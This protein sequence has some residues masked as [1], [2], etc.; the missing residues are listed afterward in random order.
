M[1]GLRQQCRAEKHFRIRQK[2][3]FTLIEIVIV[4]ALIALVSGVAVWRFDALIPAMKT[5]S[6]EKTL[7]RACTQAAHYA[8]TQKRRCFLRM[9][10]E[11]R[12]LKIEDAHGNTISAFPFAENASETELCFR[13]DTRE[14]TRIFSPS[15]LEIIDAI[16]FHPAGC[17]TPAVIE[18]LRSRKAVRCFRM[19]PFSGGLTEEEPL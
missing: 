2:P 18:I 11:T 4:I 8:W 19:D 3:A 9:D 14:S 5:P 7:M 12:N 6:P 16:E 15:E 17:T 13:L 1:H 10:A